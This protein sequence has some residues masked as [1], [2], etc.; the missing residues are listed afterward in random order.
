MSAKGIDQG[1]PNVCKGRVLATVAIWTLFLGCT[2]GQK[3]AEQAIPISGPE[4][5]AQMIAVDVQSADSQSSAFQQLA[6][7]T[8]LASKSVFSLR[9]S[10]A[11]SAFLIVG[12]RSDKGPID[13]IYPSAGSAAVP[14]SPGMPAQIP[15]AG[16]WF[17]L[18]DHPG[19]EALFVLVSTEPRKEAEAKQILSERGESA[20]VKLRDPPPEGVKER[21]RGSSLRGVLGTDG[22]AVL[23]FPFHHR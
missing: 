21:D 19:E 18:D 7:G 13:I 16:Q 20:C 17:T 14:A 22:L 12:Q 1:G 11:K 10:V 23:C 4:E 2:T 5:S 6:P 3:K 8:T 9:V 15:A